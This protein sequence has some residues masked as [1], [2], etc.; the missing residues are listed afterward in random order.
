MP[1]VLDPPPHAWEVRT[2]FGE[3]LAGPPDRVVRPAPPPGVLERHV[4]PL[5]SADPYTW[6]ASLPVGSRRLFVA[7]EGG[8]LAAGTGHALVLEGG[9]FGVLRHLPADPAPGP[10]GGLAAFLTSRFDLAV[11]PSAPWRPY[12]AVRLVVPCLE[13]RCHEGRWYAIE[14][15][16]AGEP[17]AQAPC[18]TEPEDMPRGPIDERARWDA[19][20]A[21]LLERVGDGQLVKGVLARRDAHRLHEPADPLDVL[22]R[23][24]AA[25][26]IGYRF[27]VEAG[28]ER[29]FLGVSPECLTRRRDRHV[30]TEALAGTLAPVEG[31]ASGTPLD[32]LD[33]DKDRRE[34]AVVVDH[35]VGRLRQVAARVEAAA[36]PAVEAAGRLLHLRTRVEADLDAGVHDADLLAALHPTPAV[37]GEPV[38]TALAWLRTHEGFDRGLYA[39]LVGR[40]GAFGLDVAV[41]LRSARLDG[42]E[43]IAYAGAGVVRG[44][45]ADAEWD[46]TE[47]KLGGMRAALGA[48]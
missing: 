1:P 7:R 15:R 48:S 16:V 31:G 5:A 26:G 30:W 12:G 39:G 21:A 8:E 33:S 17:P 3:P 11:A 24:D 44:S 42:S 9:D 14:Q 37:A 40:V 27:L 45:R 28:G 38:D 18:G 29:A 32:L 36:A 13:L 22:R 20:M 10:D 2:S 23:L 6:L 19:S 4:R 46:E 47:Q 34:H 35:V 25:A 43:A 41:A